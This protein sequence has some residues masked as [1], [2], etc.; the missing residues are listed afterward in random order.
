VK[1]NIVYIGLGSNIEQPFLQIKKA[2][3]AL[4]EL[5]ETVV[6]RDSGYFK[7]W[8]MGPKDQP[9]YINAVLEIE[10]TI[11]AIDLLKYCQQIEQQHGRIKLRHWGE[12][13]IDLDILLYADQQ[14]KTENLT[15]PHP[16]ILQRD[17]VYLPL[18]K[19][20]PEVNVP[21]FGPLS[22]A[23]E[24]ADRQSIKKQSIDKEYKTDYGCQFA[25]NI[26]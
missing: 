11:D 7:S 5:P 17:F 10:T 20:N 22:S 1:K 6:V 16:G 12:R 14:I 4:D 21:G 25:G 3:K 26:E 15:V 24:L 2:I 9:D 13:T 18:L 8:P 23:V 19:L